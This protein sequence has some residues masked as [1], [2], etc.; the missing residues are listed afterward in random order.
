MGIEKPVPGHVVEGVPGGGQGG[1]E[2]AGDVLR[3][4]NVVV[5]HPGRRREEM[6]RWRAGIGVDIVDEEILAAL[7]L[8][9]QGVEGVDELARLLRG[10]GAHARPLALVPPIGLRVLVPLTPDHLPGRIAR[11]RHLDDLQEGEFLREPPKAFHGRR[12]AGIGNG[13]D[14]VARGR[15]VDAGE[16]QEGRPHR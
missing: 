1:E 5:P 15:V 13:D 3:L 9:G 7:H 16:R 6:V 10:Q 2:I 8:L 4:Q 14:T 11:G 12:V